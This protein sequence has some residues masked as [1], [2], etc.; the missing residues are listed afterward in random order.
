MSAPIDLAAARRRRDV[1]TAR[2][3]LPLVVATVDDTVNVIAGTRDDGVDIWLEPDLADEIADEL[4]RCAA[5][6]RKRA[7]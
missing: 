1:R 2:G 7:K 6:A 5:D 3:T 4:K